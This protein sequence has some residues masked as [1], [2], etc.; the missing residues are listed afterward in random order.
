[1]ISGRLTAD[2]E[3]KQAGSSKLCTFCVAVNKRGKDKG[4]EFFQVNVWEWTKQAQPCKDYLFKGSQVSVQGI[5]VSNKNNDIK[6]W[7]LQADE[8]EFLSSKS[9][10]GS[11]N[12][13]NNERKVSELEEVEIS[14]MPF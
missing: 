10:G 4:A 11:N 3:L 7:N 6:Y 14:T 12:K 2:P 1:M 8:V 13:P 5:M 9:D